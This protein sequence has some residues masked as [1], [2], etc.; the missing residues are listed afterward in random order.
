MS[1]IKSVADTLEYSFVNA[2]RFRRLF[3]RLGSGLHWSR[4]LSTKGRQRTLCHRVPFSLH[5][6]ATIAAARADKLSL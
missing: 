4:Q 5:F 2:A 1:K 6:M 3:A